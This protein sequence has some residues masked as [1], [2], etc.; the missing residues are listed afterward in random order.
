MQHQ[1]NSHPGARNVKEPALAKT[2][3]NNNK[4]VSQIGAIARSAESRPQPKCPL[5][6]EFVRGEVKGVHQRIPPSTRECGTS[7]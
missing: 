3:N 6:V 1:Y 5:R 7:G 4:T 2:V